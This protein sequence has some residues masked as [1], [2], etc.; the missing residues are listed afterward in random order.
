MQC[1]ITGN[2]AFMQKPIPQT[3]SQCQLLHWECC[4][5]HLKWGEVGQRCSPPHFQIV[6]LP[7][8]V[9]QS[10]WQRRAF[11]GESLRVITLPF[12][13]SYPLCSLIFSACSYNQRLACFYYPALLCHDG[14]IIPRTMNQNIVFPQVS[15]HLFAKGNKCRLWDL[16]SKRR[17]GW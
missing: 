7:G 16:P 10:G 3:H 5:F 6:M 14:M 17:L 2:V 13:W 11:V 4:G 12:F 8:E 15:C 1:S 9:V